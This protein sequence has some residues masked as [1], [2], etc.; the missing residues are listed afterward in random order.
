[1]ITETKTKFWTIINRYDE[2]IYKL[3]HKDFKFL[4]DTYEQTREYKDKVKLKG[5]YIE[6]NNQKIWIDAE[7]NK[8][9]LKGAF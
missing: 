2:K 5:Q 8:Q 1:M 7:I 3:S 6:R 4:L 9:Y